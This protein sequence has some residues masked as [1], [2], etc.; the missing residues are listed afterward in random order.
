MNHKQKGAA[1]VELALVLPLFLLVIDGLIE[2]SLLMYDKSIVSNAAREGA[3]AGAL[4][5]NPKLTNSEIADVAKKYANTY[6]ISFGLVN[7]LQVTVNQSIDGVY[8]SPLSVSVKY[9]YTSLLAGSF[10]NSIQQ[11]LTLMTTV[12]RMNE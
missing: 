9:T 11:P 5:T 12:S 4:L 2:F 8:L 3:R 7:D 6:L 10:L 1:A